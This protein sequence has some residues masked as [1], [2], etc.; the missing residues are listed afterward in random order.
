M[1]CKYYIYKDNNTYYKYY[2]NEYNNTYYKYYVYE[3]NSIGFILDR[4]ERG[5]IYDDPQAAIIGLE[6]PP[7][8]ILENIL[9]QVL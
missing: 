9:F 6:L 7:S 3:D 1:Y 2:A 4:C 8:M 5:A